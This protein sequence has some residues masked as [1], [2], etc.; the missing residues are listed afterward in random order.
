MTAKDP[1]SASAR[2]T[3]NLGEPVSVV[4]VCL[5]EEMWRFLGLFAG[6]TGLI[7]LRARFG[8]HRGTPDQDA[9]LESLGRLAPDICLI[10]FD[11]N[12]QTAAI[13][14]ERVHSSLPETA[15]F[16]VSSQTHPE[17]ILEAMRSGC[18][19]YLVKP[20][21]RE[22]LVKAVARIG[23]RRKEKDEQGRA[24]ILAFMGSKG[25]CGTTTLA[26][27]LGA[28]LSSSFSRNSLLL[29]LHPDFGDAA[30]YLKLTKSR[31]H[32]FELLENTDRLDADFLHSF[33]MRHS[34]GLE[35]IPAPEGS[36][37]NREALPAGALTHTLSFL[38]QRYEFILLDLPPAL[39][40]ENL[41]AIQD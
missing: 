21:D 24:Q 20:I 28:L 29:D 8:D 23:A 13:V 7:Q 6:S 16:A 37:A 30:L 14:A 1:T 36:V 27:Q 2:E 31:F 10:D 41:T 3:F 40:D 9:V 39:N 33:V 12:R 19:E 22:Q 18:G 38:R 5:D 4:G 11:K 35:L 25:G 34:S 15:V 17:A 26:T 32:F